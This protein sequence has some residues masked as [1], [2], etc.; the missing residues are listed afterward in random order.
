MRTSDGVT[1]AERAQPLTPPT[2]Y[3]SSSPSTRFKRMYFFPI[4]TCI[5]LSS[6]LFKPFRSLTAV[7]LSFIFPSFY[8][9]QIISQK[10]RKSCVAIPGYSPILIDNS[11]SSRKCLN[12][13]CLARSSSNLGRNK[14]C[15]CLFT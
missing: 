10:H 8:F 14:V 3:G 7:L 11:Q 9:M 2:P 1:Q 15:V 12:T 6:D 4:Q 5:S 13:S